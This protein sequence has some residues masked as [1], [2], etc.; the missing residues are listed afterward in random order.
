MAGTLSLHPRYGTNPTI[1]LCRCCLSP[2]REVVHMGNSIPG[3]AP[4]RAI[5]DRKLCPNCEAMVRGCVVL[6]EVAPGEQGLPNPWRTGRISAVTICAAKEA[7]PTGD[8]DDPDNRVVYIDKPALQMLLGPA[9]D[10]EVR[11]SDES[12]K[13]DDVPVF[14]G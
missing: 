14:D 6:I 13:A 7:M 3:Q 9:Y 12:G 4:A 8:W 2:R 5:V 11:W 1:P 10:Q